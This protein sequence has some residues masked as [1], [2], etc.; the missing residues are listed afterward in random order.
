MTCPHAEI[1]V[2][3]LYKHKGTTIGVAWTCRAC[4]SSGSTLPHLLTPA[5]RE[6]AERVYRGEKR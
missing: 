6:E 5:Q 1:K 3:G 2:D 4:G